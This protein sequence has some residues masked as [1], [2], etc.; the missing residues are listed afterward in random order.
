MHAHRA[1]SVFK[2]CIFYRPDNTARLRPADIFIRQIALIYCPFYKTQFPERGNTNREIRLFLC[3]IECKHFHLAL[4][5][6]VGGKCFD[7]RHLAILFGFQHRPLCPLIE[8]L[9]ASAILEQQ[10]GISNSLQ[11][12]PPLTAGTGNDPEVTKQIL[13]IVVLSF[14]YSTDYKSLHIL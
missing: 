13:F 1:A 2:R 4:F 14:M 3:E 7:S 11:T 9:F 6:I 8:Q 12:A 5:F 10:E